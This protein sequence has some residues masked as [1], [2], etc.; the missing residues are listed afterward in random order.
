MTTV[1]LQA[2]GILLVL[3][4]AMAPLA[5]LR[6]FLGPSGHRRRP[7]RFGGPRRSPQRRPLEVV[8]ADLRRLDRQFSLVA[9]RPTM[10]RWRGLWSAYDRVL[11]EA[12]DLLEVPHTL[13]ETPVGLAQEIERL[14]VVTALEARGLVVR[15]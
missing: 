10:V 12:A 7:R 14:R 15:G 13:S 6:A 5:L 1:L 9:T 3:L 8:A 11:A 2:R 4:L